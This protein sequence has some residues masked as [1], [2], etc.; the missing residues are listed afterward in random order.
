MTLRWPSGK[1]W[2]ILNNLEQTGARKASSHAA[3]LRIQPTTPVQTTRRGHRLPASL[4]LWRSQAFSPRGLAMAVVTDA[5]LASL[6]SVF[7]DCC[8]SGT[9]DSQCS[10]SGP[11]CL[12]FALALA[13]PLNLSPLLSGPFLLRSPF[14]PSSLAVLGLPFR[15]FLA[16]AGPRRLALNTAED[17]NIALG[18]I[19][20]Q[21]LGL[22]FFFFLR[23]P[24]FPAPFA[25][26][27]LFTASLLPLPPFPSFA[28]VHPF[29]CCGRI[30]Y[31]A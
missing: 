13:S 14:A 18:A 2:V 21:Q 8:I 11:L 12:A 10:A 15:P 3:R 4:F 24:P 22:A 1:K 6:L 31:A 19:L 27:F 16:P 5:S 30:M 25:P 7:L 23:G 17:N 9:D 26:F 29:L 20:T 28:A